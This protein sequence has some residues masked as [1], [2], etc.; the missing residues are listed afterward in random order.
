[1]P[2]PAVAPAP[3]TTHWSR[4]FEDLPREHS[5]E[6]LGVEGDIPEDLSGTL[7]R[8][9][10]SGLTSQGLR[11]NNLFDGDGAIT[12]MR[13]ESGS[14]WGAARFVDGPDRRAERAARRPL[15][16]TYGTPSP[17][18]RGHLRR[19]MKNSANT[20]VMAWKNRLL[21][22]FEGGLPTVVDPVD[23]STE[24]E[25]DLGGVI[26]DTFSAHPQTVADHPSIFNFG[27]RHGL[28]TWLDL[29]EMCSDGQ[30]RR[31]TSVRLRRGSFIHDFALTPRHAIFCAPPIPLR[32]AQVAL[33]RATLAESFQ[34][35]PELGTEVIV[36][37]L[38]APEHVS[39]FVIEP[40]FQWHFANAFEQGDEIVVD[41]VRFEDFSA[42]D[43]V[44]NV[45][46]GHIPDHISHGSYHRMVINPQRSG[47]TSR[48]LADLSCEFPK[49][50]PA[51][52]GR[53]HRQVWLAAH[54][55]GEVGHDGVWDRLAK[56]D[57]KTG[58]TTTVSL[59]D[60]HYP[61]EPVPVTKA[62]P[63][64]PEDVWILSLTYDANSHRSYV[65]ILDGSDMEAG[66]RARVWFDHHVPTTF[67]GIWVES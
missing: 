42:N 67:H 34:W 31:V 46:R 52:E 8:N 16:P 39:R 54:S 65:A 50:A 37:P 6:L 28:R 56:L 17:T 66:P 33:G 57:V 18:L 38:D 45:H 15:Y 12:G 20:S 47:A 30:V 27:I 60:G 35:R 59:G 19:R 43:W 9:G 51:L 40:F 14:A 29:F 55:S 53:C 61:S 25:T 5:W 11:Y 64:H 21:A 49:V 62:H 1:M 63:D 10:P 4:I 23:L 41:V 36:I 26:S 2:S 44:A 24:G 58:E 22:L 7:F 13:L 48:Q 32:Y 3:S